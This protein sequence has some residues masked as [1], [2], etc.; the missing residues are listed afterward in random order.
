MA[1]ILGAWGFEQGTRTIAN[2]DRNGAGAVNDW[3]AKTGTY[4]LELYGLGDWWVRFALPGTPSDPSV[5][6]WIHGYCR[7]NDAADVNGAIRLK[8][9]LDSGDFIEL[10][11]DA[12]NNTY[13]LYVAGTKVMDGEP[14]II[15]QWPHHLQIYVV[16]AD[17]GSIRVKIDGHEGITYTGDTKPGAATGADYFYVA[18]INQRGYMIDDLVVGCGGFL[19]DLR[20]YDLRPNADTA[21]ADWTPSTGSDHYAVVDETPPNDADYL[22]T[23]TDGAADELELS[24]FDASDKVPKA[25]VAWVR[26][27]AD[28]AVGASLKIG[29]DSGGTDDTETVALSTAWEYYSHTMDEDPNTG[30]EWTDAG[31]DAGKLRIEASIP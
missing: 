4:G 17:S 12:T 8:F 25:V 6:L 24:D 22:S 30:S 28:D 31:V 3:W 19:G 13:D 11:N 16:V 21:Q 2:V 29:L 7:F 5:S 20:C 9:R 14:D 27:K 23:T 18:G 1:T 10:R 26:A 15:R